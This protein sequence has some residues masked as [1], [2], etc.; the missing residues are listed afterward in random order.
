MKFAESIEVASAAKERCACILSLD[1]LYFSPP[2]LV[3]LQRHAETAS[4]LDKVRVNLITAEQEIKRLQHDL[5]LESRLRGLPDVLQLSK[6]LAEER[7]AH[8]QCKEN[9]TTSESRVKTFDKLQYVIA[10]ES[11][12]RIH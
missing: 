6:D 1:I 10:R 3:T 7:A 9:L 4:D 11:D 12:Y 5:Q 8:T 2:N